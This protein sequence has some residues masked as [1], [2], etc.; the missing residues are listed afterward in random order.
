MS[1]LRKIQAGTSAVMVTETDAMQ[2]SSLEDDSYHDDYDD[3]AYD[4]PPSGFMKPSSSLSSEA[5]HILQALETSGFEGTPA[6][7]SDAIN[8]LIDQLPHPIS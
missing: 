7:E 5:L 2:Q 6:E 8:S 3:A 4:D 1:V